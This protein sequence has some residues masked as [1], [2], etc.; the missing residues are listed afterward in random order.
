MRHKS[1]QDIITESLVERIRS[2]EDEIADMVK[3]DEERDFKEI[4]EKKV[5]FN[6][7]V[8][9]IGFDH[10]MTIA[11][12]VDQWMQKEY[13]KDEGVAEWVECD[14]EEFDP[15]SEVYASIHGKKGA[16]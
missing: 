9:K 8:R 4:T 14:W 2:L 10:A 7:V 16:K 13:G 11:K 1:H 15:T 12:T 3:K 5:I 6:Y